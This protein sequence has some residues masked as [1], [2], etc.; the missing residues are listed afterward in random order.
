MFP[1][2]ELSVI[3]L[4]QCLKW[5]LPALPPLVLSLDIFHRLSSQSWAL[6]TLPPT[7]LA[8]R[9]VLPSSTQSHFLVKSCAA[10]DLASCIGKLDPL[11][12]HSKKNYTFSSKHLL[13]IRFIYVFMCVCGYLISICLL[14]STYN[15]RTVKTVSVSFFFSITS[16][17]E[18][19]AGR[20]VGTYEFIA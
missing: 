8:I 11:V 6:N 5:H 20:M 16:H 18:Y 4:L 10:F 7:L 12:R 17:P 15:Y 9:R 3:C 14:H 1:R 2:V 19:R 13:Q